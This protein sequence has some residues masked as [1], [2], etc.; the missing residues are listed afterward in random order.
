MKQ[1]LRFGLVGALGF[2][3]DFGMLY[4]AVTWLGLGTVAGRVL[5][6]VIAATVTWKVNR[7]FTFVQQ[8]RGS[9]REWLSYL[10]LTSVGGAI[11]VAVYQTWLWLTDHRTLNLFL[12]VAA[13]SAV[14]MLFNFAI[15]KRAVFTGNRQPS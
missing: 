4:A 3:T 1:F 7:H 15:S 14:A 2:V 10:L 11:N 5:S 9:V 13:G 8:G 12:G 6:F